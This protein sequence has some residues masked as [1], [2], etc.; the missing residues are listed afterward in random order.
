[1]RD[2]GKCVRLTYLTEK[3]ENK[4][5]IGF[6]FDLRIYDWYVWNLKKLR[7]DE[8]GRRLPMPSPNHVLEED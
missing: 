3:T 4:T 6:W 1:M 5:I 7:C 8:K 2:L